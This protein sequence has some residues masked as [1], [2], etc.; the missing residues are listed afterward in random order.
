MNR[1]IHTAH[2]D[3][4]TFFTDAR[5]FYV[6]ATLVVKDDKALLVNSFFTRSS[7]EEVVSYLKAAGLTL[8]KIFI[9]HGDPDYYFGL[10]TIREAFPK[11]YAWATKQVA[12]HIMNT[13][14]GKVTFWHPVLKEEGP[15]NPVIPAVLEGE[16]FDFEGF[17]FKVVGSDLT[18]TSLYEETEM[19]LLGGIDVFNEIHVF[20]ADTSA[21]EDRKAWISR[22]RELEALEPVI[23]IPSHG[24]AD[25][26]F[27]TK[28]LAHTAEYLEKSIEFEKETK[29]G[30]EMADK[31]LAAYPQAKNNEVVALGAGVVKKEIPW[32]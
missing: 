23:V 5:S 6:T 11:A 24:F 7:A 8:E 15:V 21:E 22:V 29:T 32:G 17:T 4:V 27:D 16:S 14:C 10:E 31:L 25:G 28:A 1:I 9:Q 20:L 26:S 2:Y 12:E 19:V 3:L 30:K 18:R 13:L